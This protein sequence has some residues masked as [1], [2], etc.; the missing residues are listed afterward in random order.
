MKALVDWNS[1]PD[2]V[3]FAASINIVLKTDWIYSGKI[4]KL[5]LIIKHN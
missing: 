2:N 3:I 5:C 1:S 4:K